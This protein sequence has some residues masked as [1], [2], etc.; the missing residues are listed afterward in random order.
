MLAVPWPHALSVVTLWVKWSLLDHSNMAIEGKQGNASVYNRSRTILPPQ[1]SL[2]LS[3]S[4]G[5]HK[6][7]YRYQDKYVFLKHCYFKLCAHMCL[8]MLML[9]VPTEAGRGYC[10][11]CAWT[12]RQFWAAHCEFWEPNSVPLKGKYVREPLSHRSNPETHFLSIDPT[13]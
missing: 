8:Y 12:Y 7:S 9:Q 1:D 5:Y 2:Y 3:Q 4:T 10:T 13:S 6:K 11:P